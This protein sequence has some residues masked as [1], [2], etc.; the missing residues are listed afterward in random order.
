MFQDYNSNL[1]CSLNKSF[2]ILKKGYWQTF[3][4]IR[5]GS[6]SRALPLR[7]EGRGNELLETPANSPPSPTTSLP[8]GTVSDLP[9]DHPDKSDVVLNGITDGGDDV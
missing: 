7:Y 9:R 3:T 6:F 8:S 5:P 2:I 4:E 1:S